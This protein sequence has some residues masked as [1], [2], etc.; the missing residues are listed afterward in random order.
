MKLSADDAT[1]YYKLMWPLQFYVNK[2][3]HILSNV[4]SMEVYIHECDYEDKL[5]VRNALYQHPE[6]IDAFADANPAQLTDEELAL[7]RG[8]KNHVAEDFYIERFL[9]KGSILIEGRK[10]KPQ[11]Y[12]VLGLMES[13]EET[14]HYYNPPIMIKTV[15][16]PF[17]GCIIYDGLVQTYSIFFGGG[18]RRN[19]KEIYLAAKQNQRIIETLEGVKPLSATSV[20]PTRDW[21]SEINELIK[22]VNKLKGEKVP[23]QSEAF[24]L[25]KT[26]AL[27]AQAAAHDPD[28]LESLWKLN[29]KVS[30]AL[31][32]LEAALNRKD[33][34]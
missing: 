13:L 20:K 12:L 4:D 32:Q 28:D 21:S 11:V 2:K 23:I 22:M 15:L 18:I 10:D 34:D 1:L 29:G 5:S 24:S 3:L 7:V 8:W 17:K 26:S 30:R 31:R 19:L 14:L 33:Y 27:L 9:A 25:L 16:L 6:L